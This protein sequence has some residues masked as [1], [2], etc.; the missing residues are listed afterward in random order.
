MQ[1]TL[2][3]IYQCLGTTYQAHLLKASPIK[4]GPTGCRETMATK[5]KSMLHYIAA[6]QRSHLHHRGSLQP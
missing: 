1:H 3:V 5:Y 2:V 4:T 6:G